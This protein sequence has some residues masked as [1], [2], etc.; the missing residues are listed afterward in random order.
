MVHQMMYSAIV[1]QN[2]SFNCRPD[3][4]ITGRDAMLTYDNLI[5]EA[6]ND[7]PMFKAKY[8]QLLDDD[9]IDIKSGI[10]IVFGYAFTPIL[11]QAIKND[12]EKAAKK[13][14]SFLEQMASSKDNLVVEVCDQSVLEA[15][16]DEFDDNILMEYMGANTQSGF[17][18]IKQFMY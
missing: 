1:G 9:V 17:M 5:Q 8:N 12:D 7:L 10:H 6:Q 15:L 18:A 4:L 3:Y 14:F 13:M 2:C 16:N 11:I